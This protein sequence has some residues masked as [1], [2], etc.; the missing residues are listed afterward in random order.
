MHKELKMHD[1]NKWKYA[2]FY[3]S[4]IKLCLYNYLFFYLF[5]LLAWPNIWI[6]CQERLWS[7]HSWKYSK[8]QR[9]PSWATDLINGVKSDDLP[10]LLP[11]ST[12]L[13]R[14]MKDNSYTM[15]K[16]G[17]NERQQFYT[18]TIAQFFECSTQLKYK[19]TQIGLK[20]FYLYLALN[21][22]YIFQQK[23]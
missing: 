17:V 2:K 14:I 19:G 10:K 1:G 3:L 15:L 6:G 12:V 11:T 8:T 5:L 18:T 20:Y 4:I 23:W 13:W 21:S 22:P 16:Q 7:L 9:T